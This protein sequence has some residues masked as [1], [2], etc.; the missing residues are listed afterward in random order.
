MKTITLIDTFAFFFRAY[1]ALPPLKNREGFPTGLLTGFVNF[2]HQ[3][4]KDH[5][6][7]YIVFALDSK[8]PT[9]REEIYP[10]YKANRPPPPEDLMKQLPVA[11]EWVRMM[12][13]ANLSKERYEAD[14]VIATLTRCGREQGITAKIV[15]SDKDLYQ[16]LD[17]RN[18]YI[19]D[20]VKRAP[21]TSRAA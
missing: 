1:Y 6:T 10:Q 9:F 20:W 4:Q 2:I 7:D 16:L 3:L 12:G 21:W 8:G 15:S 14:D 5:A 13:F 18:V 17:D 11:I 19:Y